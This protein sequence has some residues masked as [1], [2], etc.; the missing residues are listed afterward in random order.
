MFHKI[1]VN[2]ILKPLSILTLY[3]GSMGG[4]FMS[5]EVKMLGAG[6]W[7]KVE[8]DSIEKTRDNNG[9]T[10]PNLHRGKSTKTENRKIN[11]GIYGL[12]SYRTTETVVHDENSRTS[13]I[14]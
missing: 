3:I 2:S 10:N 7:K 1:Q 9:Y 14:P 13:E 6:P 5:D 8:S 4:G 11:V 12:D